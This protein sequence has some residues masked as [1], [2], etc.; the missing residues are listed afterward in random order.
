[1]KHHYV[2][3]LTVCAA[4]VINRG[5]HACGI[6]HNMSISGVFSAK[7]KD[8]TEYFRASVT[9]KE[10]HISLGSFGNEE[11]A[12]AAYAFARSYL[13]GGLDYLPDEYEKVIY[14]LDFF[15]L[16]DRTEERVKKAEEKLSFDKWIMLLNLKKTGMYCKNP[17]YVYG[18]YFVYYLDRHTV[19]KFGTDEFFFFG[20]HKL[21]KRGGHIFYSDYGMQCGLLSRYGI[22]NY[23]V[24]GRDYIF[25]NGDHLDFRYGNLVVVNRFNGVALKMI[26]GRKK[27]EVTIHL[28]SNLKVGV[29]SDEIEAAI[30][31]NKAADR[32]EETIRGK[33]YGRD[34]RITTGVENNILRSLKKKSANCG[35]LL[36]REKRK[37]DY[38]S[39]IK[40]ERILSEKK[41]GRYMLP[42]SKIMNIKFLHIS[43]N[44]GK[45]CTDSY[46]NEE[47]PYKTR[48]YRYR[49][50]KRNYV[51]GVRK[52]EYI[53]IYERLDFSRSFKRFLKKM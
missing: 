12:G 19:L 36:V 23:A 30:A 21:Q 17:I 20:K 42:R 49:R 24:E 51:E 22:K 13:N 16:S 38:T 5:C 14:G 32:L 31:Y 45:D 18:K 15:N 39:R 33:I 8:G 40:A 29:Y 47:K 6:E 11:A 41:S 10:K 43:Q 2:F 26:Q 50:W 7:K 28:R 25:K 52:K 48:T 34:N 3:M 46:I 9:Y 44:S 35:N 37:V 27:Y 4:G 1:M 53:E